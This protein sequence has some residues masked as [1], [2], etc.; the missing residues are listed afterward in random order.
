[1]LFYN[2]NYC[3]NATSEMSCPP[4]FYCGSRSVEPTPCPKGTYIET[5]EGS[6]AEGSGAEGGRYISES[7]NI[8]EHNNTK[9][10][11]EREAVT[12]QVH[13]CTRNDLIYLVTT[14]IEAL[15]ISF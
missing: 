2:S 7:Q 9:F 11:R 15:K 1:M 6:G 8:I 3:Q 13:A 4:G 10:T 5:A 14:L 12:R